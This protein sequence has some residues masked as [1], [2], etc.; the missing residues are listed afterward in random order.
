MSVKF[1]G[2]FKRTAI[3]LSLLFLLGVTGCQDTGSLSETSVPKIPENLNPDNSIGISG[4]GDSVDTHSN[5]ASKELVIHYMDVGQGDAT[6]ITCGG[7]AM[8]IDAGDNSMGTKVQM[9]LSSQN[10]TKLDYV[11]GTHPDAD[12]IGGLDV[13]I[14][15]FDCE[16]IFLTG[17]KGYLDL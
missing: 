8:L 17:R 6:L 3:I 14:T 4:V 5:N 15:K 2:C 13:V 11:I 1:F 12:H 16:T 10:I 7:E 9:Y